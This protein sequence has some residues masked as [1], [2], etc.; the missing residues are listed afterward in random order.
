MGRGK[1][2]GKP[3]GRRHFS[4]PEE[5]RAGTS[6]RPRGFRQED[7]QNEEEEEVEQEE[8]SGEESEESNEK[9]KGTQGLIEIENPNI[10]KPRNVKA[11]DI[12]MEKTTE[13]SRREREELEKQRARERYMRLQEQ[14]KTEQ[15]RKDLERLQLIRQQREEAARR[16]E[17]EKA[18]KEQK[19][20]EARK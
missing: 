9:K 6:N 1:F 5:I 20:A 8:S 4:T 18:A 13:L 16:R 10:V 11:R 15:A 7:E 14:G 17:E 2:K 3:T 19:R 12:D